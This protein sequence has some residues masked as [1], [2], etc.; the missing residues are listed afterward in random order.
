MDYQPS[1]RDGFTGRPTSTLP[2]HCTFPSRKLYPVPEYEAEIFAGSKS[3]QHDDSSTLPG[4]R[5]GD[6][7]RD[8][9][10]R[11][12]SRSSTSPQAHRLRAWFS[13]PLEKSEDPIGQNCRAYQWTTPARLVLHVVSFAAS[14]ATVTLL[15]Q[16]LIAHRKLRYVRQ[17]SGADN[18]WP[19]EMSF[20]ASIILLAAASVNVVK[21]ASFFV[22]EIYYRTRSHSNMLLVVSTASSITMAAI[23]VAV[24]VFVEVNRRNNEDFATWSCARSEAVFNEIVPYR[25]ICDE[26]VKLAIYP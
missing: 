21:S 11:D 14:L 4:P 18:A 3:A 16:A 7:D 17:F 2:S 12:S 22:V 8:W 10:M 26:E 6:L 5:D 15:A 1:S 25:A 24:S 20:T 23:W 19:K 13:C 9:N